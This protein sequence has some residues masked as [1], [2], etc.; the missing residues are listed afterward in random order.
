MVSGYGCVKGLVLLASAISA[1]ICVAVKARSCS[2]QLC[3]FKTWRRC[4][5]A[6]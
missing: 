2:Q 1:Q 6:L 3:S 5:H 4:S